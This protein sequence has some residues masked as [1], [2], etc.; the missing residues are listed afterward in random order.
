MSEMTREEVD[1]LAGP[2]VLEFGTSWCSHCR[3]MQ[4]LLADELESHPM[5]RHIKI[6]DGPGQRLGR[7]FHV[8]QWPTL[9]FMNEGRIVSLLVRPMADEIAKAFADLLASNEH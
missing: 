7:T 8:K 2:I 1:K 6:E 4:P 5:V 3:A 9:V